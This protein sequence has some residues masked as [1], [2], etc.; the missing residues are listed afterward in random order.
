MG[1]LECPDAQGEW[2]DVIERLPNFMRWQREGELYDRARAG[3]FGK[4]YIDAQRKHVAL[5]ERDF[6]P[7]A[8]QILTEADWKV[9]SDDADVSSPS[10]D[11]VFGPAVIEPYRNIRDSIQKGLE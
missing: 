6:F 9:I 4:A 7:R 2:V 8:A 10:A 3:E 11:P 1:L 5:E